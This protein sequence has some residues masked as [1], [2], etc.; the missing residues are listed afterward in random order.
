MGMRSSL[1]KN[2]VTCSA[3][4]MIGLFHDPLSAQELPAYTPSNPLK[5]GTKI[6]EPFAMK[7]EDGKWYG[8]SIELWDLIAKRLGIPYVWEQ[9]DLNSLLLDVEKGSLDAGIA[10]MTITA[11][12]E[13]RLDFSHA[14]YSTGL[15][16]VTPSHLNG[17]WKSI[18]RGI[19]SRQIFYT[20]LALLLT[21]FLVGAITWLI[22]RK[23]NPDTF[24]P[25]PVKGIASG[26]W[27]AAVTMTTVGYGDMTPRTLGGRLIALFWMFTSLMIVSAII[28]S[29]AS[30]LTIAHSKPLISSKEDL[31]KGRLVSIRNSSSDKYL[32]K[33]HL[34]ADYYPSV[35]QA[36]AAIDRGD[37]DAMVYDNPLLKYLTK[38]N[39]DNRLRVIDT[40]IEPQQYGIIFPEGSPLREPVNRV[41]LD[42]IKKDAWKRILSNYL[43]PAR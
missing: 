25:N 12:R 21:L 1:Y 22:E 13:A 43:G 35:K 38:N 17:G 19:F 32:Y 8:I 7:D 27:W 37:A 14:Y 28:G 5:V 11:D 4:L 2:I 41:M 36:L 31:H 39:F 18:L 30:A 10:A 40:I 24:H 16:I 34:K 33:H 3:I 9:R 15:S 42:I 23:K 20:V 26:I 6:A 29:V